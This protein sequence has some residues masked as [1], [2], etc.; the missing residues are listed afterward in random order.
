MKNTLIILLSLIVISCVETDS[1]KSRADES[2][3]IA[4][5]HEYEGASL[6]EDTGVAAA[7]EYYLSQEP[8]DTL[9]VL[10]AA[11]LTASHL[12]WIGE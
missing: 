7:L 12:W 1:A 10:R 9:A 8:L 6:S 3:Q 11:R 2:I 5:Q 4:L